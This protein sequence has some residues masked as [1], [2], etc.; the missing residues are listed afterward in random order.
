MSYREIMR[1]CHRQA[2]EETMEWLKKTGDY[3]RVMLESWMELYTDEFEHG[4]SALDHRPTEEPQFRVTL[5]QCAKE[6][7]CCYP[8]DCQRCGERLPNLTQTDIFDLWAHLD[9]ENIADYECGE[10]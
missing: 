10:S 5:S 8:N 9:P 4:Q 1:R 7:R 2:V 3:N 6:G